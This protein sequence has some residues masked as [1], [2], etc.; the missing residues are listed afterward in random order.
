MALFL[1]QLEGVTLN[2]SQKNSK[3]KVPVLKTL[4]LTKLVKYF[5]INQGIFLP[6]LA[7]LIYQTY[8]GK[9][10]SVMF[11]IFC[12]V[13]AAIRG[14]LRDVLVSFVYGRR[15]GK[16][17]LGQSQ[18]QC[19]FKDST[20]LGL[21]I[22]DHFVMFSKFLRIVSPKKGSSKQGLYLWALPPVCTYLLKPDLK[23]L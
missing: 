19:S 23:H 11:Y 2:L 4:T 21:K 6:R 13:E 14:I 7:L 22:A 8:S 1:S 9:C 12:L 5:L 20:R 15:K 10:S 18:F 16:Q 3:T 17:I